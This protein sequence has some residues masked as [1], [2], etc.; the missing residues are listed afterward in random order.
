MYHQT[1][2]P[3]VLTTLAQRNR[4]RETMI[5][6]SAVRFQSFSFPALKGGEILKGLCRHGSLPQ[7]GMDVMEFSI[8]QHSLIPVIKQI[9]EQVKL[10]VW[11][12]TI[13]SGDS[14][15]SIR[16]V[17]R[18]TGVNR[19][20]VYR[21]YKALGQSGVLVLNRGRGK[22]AVVSTPA[23][24]RDSINSKCSTLTRNIA[25][26]VRRLGI[27]PTAYA[28]YLSQQMQELERRAPF[29]AYVDPLKTF[30]LSKAAELSQ[31]WQVP[32]IGLTTLELKS[33]A[34]K[35]TQPR[36][37]LTSHL[38]HDFVQSSL[39]GRK[40]EVIPVEVRYSD[41]MI[42]ELDRIRPHSSVLRVLPPHFLPY[43]GF[44]RAQL[45]KRIKAP[46]VGISLVSVADRSFEML[47]KGSKY[48]FIIV[49][50]TLLSEIP[51]E[52]QKSCKILMVQMQLD[53]KSLEA[54]RI[55]AGVIV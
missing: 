41:Q 50:P 42:K 19:A 26:K 35:G 2:K 54:V 33:A 7:K 5:L 43:A 28:R 37:A 20:Q 47:L 10:A 49:D 46:D 55:R 27:S 29:I 39:P 25:A 36:K 12:G 34:R 53:Q 1:G 24:S 38:I 48:D 22:G 11:M 31:L 9:Q 16:E 51:H 15:P 13:H 52:V 14:L 44:I 4:Y 21:A 3:V 30:A 18:K 45:Q 6:E 8:E 40:I 23:A 32:V 17:E